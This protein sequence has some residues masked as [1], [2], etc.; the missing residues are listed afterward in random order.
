MGAVDTTQLPAHDC[1]GERND[2]NRRDGPTGRNSLIWRRAPARVKIYIERTTHDSWW[3][4]MPH[5]TPWIGFEDLISLLRGRPIAVLSGAG[6]STESGIPDYR[7][8][9]TRDRDHDPI[10]YQAFVS[11]SAVRSHYWARSAIGWPTFASAQ[12]NDGHRA[13][14]RLEDAGPIE[15]IITQ[16]VDGLHQA[17]GSSH[18]VELHG[19]LSEVECLDCEALVSRQHLQ[20]RLNRLNPHWTDRAAEIN[21]DGDAQLPRSATRGFC[22]PSC[23]NCGGVLKPH[24]VFFGE[25]ADPARVDAAWNVLREAEVLLVL[26]SSLTVYSGYRFVRTAA[27]NDVPIGIVNLGDTRG[28]PHATVHLEG[29]TGVVLPPVAD[30][31][32]P[33]V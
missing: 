20:R 23:P 30:A 14:A 1:C 21:P 18:V 7:G 16:N 19:S 27:Q 28:T 6:I 22:V 17:A 9:E 29:R 13:L 12:P 8:P 15:G 10:R 4:V 31:L 32:L 2:A 5:P 25:N 26:G 11:S 33:S 3:F 24:V